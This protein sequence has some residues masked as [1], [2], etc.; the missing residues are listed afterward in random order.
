M[1]QVGWSGTGGKKGGRTNL[2][3]EYAPGL[4]A[5]VSDLDMFFY[6]SEIRNA[7]KNRVFLVNI[8]RGKYIYKSKIFKIKF[9]K[10][11]SNQKELKDLIYIVAQNTMLT[12]RVKF[13]I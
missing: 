9:L 11:L 10:I 5:R 3:S 7:N 2:V 6:Q 1:I 12:S 13:I 8:C 4:Q